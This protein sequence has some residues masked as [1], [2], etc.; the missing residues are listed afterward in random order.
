MVGLYGEPL[1]G[2][3][4]APADLVGLARTLR[5]AGDLE[6]AWGAANEAVERGAGHDSLRARAEIARA[7]GDKAHAMSDFEAVVAEVDCGKTRLEL[8][9][10]YEHFVKQPARALSIAMAGTS[11]TEERAARRAARLARKVEKLTSS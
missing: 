7:R 11:E 10:L 3:Q 1:E 9:K 8:A 2:S 5:R 6:L 4:L